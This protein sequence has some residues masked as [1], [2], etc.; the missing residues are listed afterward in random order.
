M[1]F[2]SDELPPGILIAS[3][4]RDSP[5]VSRN[6]KLTCSKGHAIFAWPIRARGFLVMMRNVSHDLRY[7]KKYDC[8][9]LF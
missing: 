5:L 3:E 1:S 6:Y 4:I 7:L 9:V 2:A 8:L